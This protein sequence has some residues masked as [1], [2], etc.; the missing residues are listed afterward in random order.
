MLQKIVNWKKIN[1]KRLPKR[2][3]NGI[4]IP[5]LHKRQFHMT[6]KSRQSYPLKSALKNEE[7][8]INN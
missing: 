8:T 1:I 4:C 5:T 7:T 3:Y 6:K 2:N